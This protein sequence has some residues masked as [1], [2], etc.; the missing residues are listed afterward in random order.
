[1]SPKIRPLRHWLAF[2][3]LLMAVVA[4]ILAPAQVAL[5]QDEPARVAVSDPYW[6]AAYFKNTSLAGDPVLLRNEPNLD[7][8]WG[9]GGPEGLQSDFFSARFTRYI[10]TEAAVYRFTVTSDDGVRVW[11]NDE[12]VLDQWREQSERTFVVDRNLSA[13]HQLVRVEYFEAT[14]SARIR[15]KWER[16]GTT[17]QP[18]T[19]AVWRGEYWN[20]RTLSGDP[21]LVRDDANVNFNW[22]LGSPDSRIQVNDFSARWTR[23]SDLGS[24]TFRFTVSSDDGV[25][26]WVNNTLIIDQWNVQSLRTFSAD[27]FLPGGTIPLRVEYFEATQNATIQLS[28][29]RVD[30]GGGGGGGSEEV[31][32]C[33]QDSHWRAQ[34]WNNDRLEGDPVFERN[35]DE[36]D[37]DWGYGSPDPRINADWFS[38]RWTRRLCL[39]EGRTHFAVEV[40]DGARLFVNGRLI[41]DTWIA[42]DRN[43][44]TA[45]VQ[46]S[47][48]RHKIVLEY[49]ER[50]KLAS[51][52]LEV[53]PPEVPNRTP[54]GNLVT[55]VP[56]QPDNYAWIKLYRL[57]G[58]NQWYSIG[59]GIGAIEPSG[60]LKIDGLPVDVGRFGAQGE[61][62]K[63]ELWWNGKV[64][65]STGDFLN[66]QPEFRMRPFVDN[67]TPWGC[68][69]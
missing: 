59:R 8:N 57:N 58:N 34:F 64:V 47:E 48:G 26:V 33:D 39:P 30:S 68:I 54:I 5:A 62:Y 3:M 45:S 40:D 17:P 11:I 36:I 37:F 29:Q 6:V 69:H 65:R 49:M 56:P 25:R 22:G 43:R 12:L 23:N 1:M 7:N 46:L 19:G 31:D 24:G 53:T 13:G 60:F 35:D 2:A 27:I 10:L 4:P 52:L 55:C 9:T 15:V 14:G 66:G 51:V 32:D 63:L 28:W 44:Y 20:N 21:A 38:V 18:P 50:T 61:P 42:Q 41:I 67:S 16:L